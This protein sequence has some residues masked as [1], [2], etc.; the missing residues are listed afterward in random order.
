LY[1]KHTSDFFYA[2]KRASTN[3]RF[4]AAVWAKPCDVRATEKRST[5]SPATP[6]KLVA[7]GGIEPPTQGFSTLIDRAK[8]VVQLAFL[9]TSVFGV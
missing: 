4:S 6:Y 5:F 2:G 9:F 8:P 3:Q 1:I 7:W